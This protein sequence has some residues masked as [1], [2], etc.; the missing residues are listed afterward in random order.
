MSTQTTKKIH[1]EFQ[2][3]KQRATLRLKRS[4]VF[5]GLDELTRK[6]MQFEI[7]R[8][9]TSAYFDGRND[10]IEAMARVLDLR[11]E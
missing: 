10:G 5:Q 7:D 3:A 2:A 11:S 4:P 1:V 9:I 6:W 8:I